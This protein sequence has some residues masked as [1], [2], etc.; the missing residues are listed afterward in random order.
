MDL[1]T[2]KYNNRV[3]YDVSTHCK[4]MLHDRFVGSN[5]T[6]FFFVC[7]CVCVCV[8]LFVNILQATIFIMCEWRD[9]LSTNSYAK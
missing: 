2:F 1:L 4:Q 5:G 6:F 7:V 8:C 3:I 9:F